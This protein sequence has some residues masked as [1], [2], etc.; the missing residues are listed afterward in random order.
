[1]PTDLN[2]FE[3]KNTSVLIYNFSIT[4]KKGNAEWIKLEKNEQVLN[5]LLHDLFKRGLNS[6]IVEGGTFTLS[7]F[8]NAGLWNEARVFKAPH[9][10]GSGIAAPKL[11][12]AKVLTNQAIGSDR[13]SCIINTENFN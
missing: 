12:V 1:L 2:I 3:D 11:P 8:I 6:V 7:S 5:Q 4:E 9:S 10:L 13:L